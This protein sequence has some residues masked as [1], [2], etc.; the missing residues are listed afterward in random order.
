MAEE[1]GQE[2][3]GE[4]VRGLLHIAQGAVHWFCNPRLWMILWQLWIF[5][6]REI[7]RKYQPSK[8]TVEF[9][10]WHAITPVLFIA[11]CYTPAAPVCCSLRRA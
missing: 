5:E 9:I 1:W 3:E 4:A 11:L 7:V 2:E 6:G 8:Q 10:R